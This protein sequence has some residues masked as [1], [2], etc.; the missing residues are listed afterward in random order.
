M[1]ELLSSSSSDTD[2]Q[3]FRRNSFSIELSFSTADIENTLFYGEME[4]AQPQA[5]LEEVEAE[6]TEGEM[7]LLVHGEMYKLRREPYPSGANPLTE[8]SVL[9]RLVDG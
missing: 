5:P 3:D 6:E 8:E 4:M 7:A 2:L 9:F 1:S